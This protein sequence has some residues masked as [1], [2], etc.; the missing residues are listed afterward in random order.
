MTAGVCFHC[1]QR[2][3]SLQPLEFVTPAFNPVGS[4]PV[5]TAKSG[6]LFE[7]DAAFLLATRGASSDLPFSLGQ[8]GASTEAGDRNHL[9]VGLLG[10]CLKM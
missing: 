7:R 5:P 3:P 4:L 2:T 10:S 1:K 8:S 6:I 9:P